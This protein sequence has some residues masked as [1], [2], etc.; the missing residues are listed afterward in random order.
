MK[1]AD[2]HLHT[3]F[4]DGTFTPEE[5]VLRAQNCGL[6]CIALTDHDTVEGC[7]RAAAACAAAKMEF[8]SGAELT[9]EHDDTEVHILGYF[10]DTKNK[11]LLDRIAK[12]QAV[13]QN[14]I[15]EMCDALN[16]LGIPL[17][18]E[19]VFALANCKSPGRPHVA[20]AM[21][22]EKLIGNLDQAF[23]KYLKKGKP[24]WVPKTKMSAL[25]GVELIH[26]A[27]GLAVMAHPG[28]NR[29]DDIIP[30]LIKAGLDGIECF[31]TKHSTVMAE[32][33]LEIAEKYDLLV[34][35]GSDCHG[36]SKK[37]PL[38]GTVKLPYEHVEKLFAAKKAADGKR[39]A[40]A[41]K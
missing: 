21:V 36:F 24:A 22:K 15:N 17:K 37:A 16:K 18:A 4:S 26:Q 29:T 41:V 31:H 35:G 7:A 14:R 13:R 40:I 5:L 3:Q 19:S 1:F 25:E 28:L 30:D 32:R 33:Y 12:F 2:L 23:E 6:A 11:V 10:L 20:R 39:R 8:I 34:T 27:G 9:A 38:I